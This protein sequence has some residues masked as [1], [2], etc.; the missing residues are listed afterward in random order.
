M[1]RTSDTLSRLDSDAAETTELYDDIPTFPVIAS[2][3]D[4]EEQVKPWHIRQR[5]LRRP[6]NLRREMSP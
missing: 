4:S 3:R 6:N 5:T 1:N 2:I